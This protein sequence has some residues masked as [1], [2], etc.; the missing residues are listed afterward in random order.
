MR[1]SDVKEQDWQLFRSRFSQWQEA[2]M[3]K[4]SSE[5]V[6]MLMADGKAFEKFWALEQRLRKDK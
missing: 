1:E 4:L 6:A 2:Y 5:Y 3:E